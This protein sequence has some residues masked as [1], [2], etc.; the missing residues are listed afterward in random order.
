MIKKQINNSIK[1]VLVFLA[2]AIQS[3]SFDSV[4]EEKIDLPEA[5]WAEDSIQT[6][7]FEIKETGKYN[8]F[9]LVKN[10]SDYPFSNL[11]LKSDL[12][13]TDKSISKK[14]QEITLFDKKTGR[15]YGRGFGGTM[16]SKFYALQEI[17]LK[18]GVYTLSVQQYMR[19]PLLKGVLAFGIKVDKVTKQHIGK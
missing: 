12:R 16:E 2:F 14:L 15:P 6:F 18:E 3:C 17:D 8:V 10:K 13:D 11:Y 5:I 1:F 9:Y 19:E 4:Y 7:Q